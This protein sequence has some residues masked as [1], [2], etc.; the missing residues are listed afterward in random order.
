MKIKDRR[1]ILNDI[2]NTWGIELKTKKLS[3]GRKL[4]HTFQEDTAKKRN[5][6]IHGGDLI[7]EDESIIAINCVNSY[8]NEVVTEVAD[9]FGLP[10]KDTGNWGEHYT[11]GSHFEQ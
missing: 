8:L 7:T 4:W 10:F 9:R 11:T 5:Y 3:D 1:E 6:F 2:L